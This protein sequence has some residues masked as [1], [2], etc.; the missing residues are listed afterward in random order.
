MLNALSQ[1]LQYAGRMLARRPLFTAIAILTIA[2]GIGANTAIFSV[3]NSALLKPLP[4]PHGRRLAVVWSSFGNEGRAPSSGHE[5]VSLRERSRFFEQFAGIWVQSGA[6]TGK[7]E[8]QQVK[9]GWVT[10]NFLELLNAH[11]QAG[12][13]FLPEEQG[14]GRAPVAVLSHELWQSRYGADPTIVGKAVQLSG[15]LCTIVGVL[16]R[17]FQLIF[18][19][20]ASVPPNVDIY[21][22][23]QDD[24]AKQPRDQAYIR[25]VGRLRAGASVQQAQAE[26]DNIAA[27]LRAGFR[28]YSEQNLR[29]QTLPLQADVAHKVRPSL[30]TLFAGTGFVL[31]IVCANL[32]MLVL[33]R[34]NERRSEIAM[35]AALG[36]NPS[37]IIR[38]LLTENLF[39][40]FLGGIGGM[41]LALGILRILWIL[42]PAGVART[43]PRDLDVTVL[44][45]NLILSAVC[46][47]LFGLFPAFETRLLDLAG[48]LRST[49][50]TT[51][52]GRTAFR[53]LLV[54]CQVALTFVLL[55]GSALLIR[56]FVSLLQV[57]PGFNPANVLTFQASLANVRYPTPD[58]SINFIREAQKTL[59][60]LPGVQSVGV[61]S[62]LPFDDNLPNWYSYYWREGAPAQDQNTLM[63]DHRSALPDF[64]NSLG[65]TFVSGRNFNGTDDQANR[66]VVIIDD[67]LANQ[68]WPHGNAVGQL[69]NIENGDFVRD[70]AEVIGVVK[71]V[72]F[73]SLT[74]PVRP[75]VYLRYPMAVRANMSFTV[76][77]NLSREALLPMVRGAMAKLDKDLPVANPRPLVDYV[78]DTRRETRFITVL[79]GAMAVIAL[80]L[81]CVGIYGVTSASV[82]RRTKEIGVRLALGAQ[83]REIV[84]IVLRGS[85]PAVIIGAAVGF[86]FTFI[87]MPLLS[88][89]LVGVRPIEPTVLISVSLLLALVGLIA[90]CVPVQRVLR[91]NPLNALRYE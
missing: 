11:P 35:R 67:L 84:T 8:P 70:V 52:D 63:A 47:L 91:R 25:I 56:T 32:A 43:T 49:S 64:F 58:R 81:S 37:R 10:S 48:V 45:F 51:T 3:I 60:A 85:M 21:V 15:R 38:Q 71:H 12:R 26:L 59:A 74:N 16:P 34:G 41:A 73:H 83:E 65:V 86:V 27:Q 75:Q 23:F 9:L 53:H 46:G 18:P 4:Y 2:I 80:L 62:H 24:L 17:G 19:E 40:A 33:A 82:S 39:L 89:L 44:L 50:T 68:L 36:A 55:V 54:G 6:L 69:L 42:Q 72:Q 1:D 30:L 13:F 5:L 22:P 61:V 57:E 78:S 66:K 14:G 31:V 90:S 87:L 76:R 79:C 77:S 20:G 28:E 7:G 88:S 29:L